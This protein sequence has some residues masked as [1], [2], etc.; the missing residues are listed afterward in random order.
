MVSIT[1][2]N[3]NNETYYYLTYSYREGGKGKLLEKPLGKD[4]NKYGLEGI[5]KI[6]EEF[7]IEIFQKRWEDIIEEIKQ[8]YES[9]LHKLPEIIRQN[10]LKDFGIRFTH[11]TNKIEGSKLSLRDVAVITNDQYI[12]INKPVLDINEAQFHMDC[13][14]DMIKTEKELSPELIKRWHKKLFKKTSTEDNIAGEFRK[15]N[16]RIS[17]SRAVFPEGYLVAEL[18]NDLFKWYDEKKEKINPVLLSCLMHF[19]FI[20]I[21][22]FGDGNGRMTRLLMNY[23]LFKNHYSM[24]DIAYDIR[25]QYFKN[26]EKAQIKNDETF[27]VNWFFKNYL[28]YFNNNPFFNQKQMSL[29]KIILKSG[30]YSISITEEKLNLYTGTCSKNA[31]EMLNRGW[32]PSKKCNYSPFERRN[33]LFLVNNPKTALYYAEIKDCSTVLKV[34][35]PISFLIPDLDDSFEYTIIELIQEMKEKP[36]DEYQFTLIKAIPKEAFSLVC[37]SAIIDGIFKFIDCKEVLN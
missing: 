20:S 4:L 11:N 37:G 25:L 3:V 24:F 15:H 2:K 18:I 10:R 6:R 22:P 32:K 19:R 36:N 13:Y 23:I 30:L 27:F 31:T 29:R 12:P 21:H 8:K 35:V 16:I 7:T 14:Y 5:L 9:N 26:L 34:C 1:K 33:V 28:K 17:G